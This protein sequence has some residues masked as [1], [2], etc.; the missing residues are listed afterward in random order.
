LEDGGGAQ[1][2]S[3]RMIAAFANSL[4]VDL[5]AFGRDRGDGIDAHDLA[6]ALIEPT[7]GF[8]QGVFGLVNN[9]FDIVGAEADRRA[10]VVIRDPA[11]A[12]R[13]LSLCL[14]CFVVAVRTSATLAL[15]AALP[16]WLL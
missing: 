4:D 7:I 13:R 3:E 8:D 15:L 6:V 16:R 11:A 1:V 5:D 10:M 12:Q 9:P 2:L 14:R